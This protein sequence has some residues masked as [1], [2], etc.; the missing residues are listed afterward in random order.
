MSPNLCPEC[1]QYFADVAKGPVCP[2]CQK[3]PPEKRREVRRVEKA[4]GPFATINARLDRLESMVSDMQFA[5]ERSDEDEQ[6]EVPEA[7]EEE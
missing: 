4:D 3:K 5:L 6:E 1:G 2:A 7:G